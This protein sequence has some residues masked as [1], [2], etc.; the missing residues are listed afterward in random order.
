MP[1]IGS[2][3]A[4]EDRLRYALWHLLERLDILGSTV[5]SDDNLVWLVYNADVG[6][7]VSSKRE[8]E[9]TLWCEDIPF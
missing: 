5:P 8:H 3:S 7:K 9:C 6:Q 4:N 2:K 1:R